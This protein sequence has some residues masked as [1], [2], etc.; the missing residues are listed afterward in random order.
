M[1]FRNAIYTT[2]LVF[3]VFIFFFNFCQSPS[4]PDFIT[5]SDTEISLL[6]PDTTTIQIKV[7]D[8]VTIG[9][10]RTYPVYIDS[11]RL[12]LDTDTTLWYHKGSVTLPDRDIG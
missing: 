8:T 11:M 7:G 2:L 12:D 3:S 10:D 6:L 9:I 5:S 4:K 1:F